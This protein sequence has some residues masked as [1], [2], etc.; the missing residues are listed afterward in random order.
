MTSYKSSNNIVFSCKYHVV[1]CTKYRRKVLIND[2]EK[3]LKII[4]EEVCEE[5]RCELFEIKCDQ[6]HVHILVEVGPQFGIH[7]LIKAIKGR[8]SKLL[9][10]EFKS[11]TT[12]LPTLWTNSYFVSTSGSAPSAKIKE[13]I[14]NQKTSQRQ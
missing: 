5:L 13:Y 3:R 2:V 11:L 1:W 4:T 10:S 9:R 8:S 6:D 7:K 12:K 14:Q